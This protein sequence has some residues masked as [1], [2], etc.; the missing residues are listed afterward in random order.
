MQKL[1]FTNGGG[2]TIDL[3]SGNFGITNW[4]GLSNTG[5]NIQTQ[6]VP[7]Q[8]GG[9]F[10]DALMEQRE[11]S[12][13]VAIQDNNDLSA[14]Y[15]RKRQLI[16]ALNPKLGEGVLVYTN[17][18]L[19][20]QIKAVPQLPIFENKNSND[21]GTLKA[22]VTFSCPSP[23]WEDLEDTVVNFGF[24][25][26]PIIENEGDVPTQIEMEW[27]TNGV[28]DG[29]VYNKTTGQ[30]LTYNGTLG[31]NLRVNTNIGKKSVSSENFTFTYMELGDRF[32]MC[33]AKT[34]EAIL[35]VS[36]TGIAMLSKDGENWQTGTLGSST[37]DD[38]TYSDKLGMFVA[39]GSQGKI[40]TSYD[41]L[42]WT[43]RTSGTTDN[44]YGVMYSE[45]KELFVITGNNGTILTSSD[46]INWTSQTS[47]VSVALY[48]VAYS[49][50]M[51]IFVISG[52]SGTILTSTN[53][54]DWTER[55][56][57]VT[58]KLY[59]VCYS[60]K[61][62][63]FLITSDSSTNT[64][65]STDGINWQEGT[66]SNSVY[67]VAFCGVLGLFIAVGRNG[68][69]NTSPDGMNWTTTQLQETVALYGA[70]YSDSL[71]KIFVSGESGVIAE[72]INSTEWIVIKKG[73]TETIYDVCY[74]KDL[75]LYVAVGG[76]NRAYVMTST[77]FINWTERFTDGST[78][79]YPL[80]T[81]CYSQE[82]HLF[83]TTSQYGKMYS[84]T[85]GIN[86]V[87]VTTGLGTIEMD[88]VIYAKTPELF[89]VVGDGIWTSPDG[90]TW[91]AQ[92]TTTHISADIY[93]VCYAE[94][95]GMFVAVAQNNTYSLY[96]Y[97][98]V[99]WFETG[100]KTNNRKAY[101]CY[102]E[103]LGIFVCCTYSEGIWTSYDGLIWAKRQGGSNNAKIMYSEIKRM[104]INNNHISSD[105]LNWTRIEQGASNIV[106]SE[107][108]NCFYAISGTTSLKSIYIPIGNCIDKISSDSDMGMNL[109]VGQ[110]KFLA[111]STEGEISVQI[112]YRQKYIGV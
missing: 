90:S 110:N 88:C 1:V 84:S 46:G 27:T 14:R 8:D 50:N 3:T 36:S 96:S 94:N 98:G 25:E 29:T 79:Q 58:T 71:K 97:N 65:L 104:F 73:F 45:K 20:R 9:V 5:L 109:A 70:I 23:Y 19:S 63:L 57:G 107:E 26:Q 51:N 28:T 78:S 16:S 34:I 75:G 92:A 40:R 6:Q 2:Q 72:S 60:F 47:G 89:V 64:L 76:S 69:I 38:V 43:T 83:V 108:D 85:D 95:K 102:S 101:V 67:E 54:T 18:Y 91:T 100:F 61:L 49:D 82:K 41:G 86:W 39:V 55:T 77:D 11:I 31:N 87:S 17:D 35:A 105:G 42:E 13:T 48:S 22:N 37:Y 44:L 66:I 33:Y 112:K 4:E 15:E 53:G 111:T 80:K 62:G 68:T 74:A 106:Y 103:K 12:V 52:Y 81:I 59:R 10:L 32:T 93:S 7:F 56:S 21:A 24:N 30:K 99:D